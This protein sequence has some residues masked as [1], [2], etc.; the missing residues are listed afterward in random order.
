MPF[1]RTTQTLT[2]AATRL[3]T[4]LGTVKAEL[5]A[6]GGADDDYLRGV[7]LRASSA[8]EDYCNRVFAREALQ[9]TFLFRFERGPM[10]AQ[11]A[12][13]LLVLSRSPVVSIQSLT[14]NATTLVE[15]TD[16]VTDQST[17]ILTRLDASGRP[18]VW[19]CYTIIVQFTAGWLLPNDQGR[20]LP[21]SVEDAV[22]LLVKE[23]WSARGRDPSLKS[24]TVEGVYSATYWLG[25]TG[26]VGDL[27]APAGAKLDRYRFPPAR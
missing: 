19:P 4:S 21:G 11:S 20:T 26:E 9:D 23:A 17:G 27:P 25:S 22:L 12:P 3:L 16:F 7:I 6:T 8:A 1:E 15:G 5:K 10:M 2:P 14:E 18:T 24:E 13:A